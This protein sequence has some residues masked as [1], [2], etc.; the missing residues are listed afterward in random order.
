MIQAYIGDIG[1]RE[2]LFRRKVPEVTT[3]YCGLYE[4]EGKEIV[5]HLAV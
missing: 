2:Y 3:P 1:L 5:E 4:G